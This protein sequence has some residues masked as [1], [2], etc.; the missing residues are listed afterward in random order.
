MRYAEVSPPIEPRPSAAWLVRLPKGRKR[1][2]I[3]HPKMTLL[4]VKEIVRRSF[5]Q[6]KI[7]QVTVGEF[8]VAA[9]DHMYSSDSRAVDHKGR[10]RL[11]DG[12]P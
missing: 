7:E 12:D 10:V 1:L 2:L 6:F 3:V 11:D 4:E 5:P 8:E 9:I